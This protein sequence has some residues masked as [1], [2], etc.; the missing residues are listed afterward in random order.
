MG[1]GWCAHPSAAHSDTDLALL[2]TYAQANASDSQALFE[3]V[4][5]SSYRLRE[6]LHAAAI[7]LRD[8]VMAG[9]E[10]SFLQHGI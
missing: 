8:S 4:R 5:H 9:F 6:D 1:L 10:S 7:P 3:S 2:V